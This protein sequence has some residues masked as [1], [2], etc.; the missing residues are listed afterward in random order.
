MVGCWLAGLAGN[1]TNLAP[2]WSVGLGD[3]IIKINVNN[4]GD[5]IFENDGSSIILC[6]PI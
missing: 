5:I 6:A 3:V 4:N 2:N 1:E